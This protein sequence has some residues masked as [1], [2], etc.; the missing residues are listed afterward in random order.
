VLIAVKHQSTAT[1]LAQVIRHGI[2]AVMSSTFERREPISL[3]TSQL[4]NSSTN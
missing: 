1:Q 4:Q 3:I 2:H